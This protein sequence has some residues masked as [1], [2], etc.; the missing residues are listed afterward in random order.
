MYL[1]Y[2]TADICAKE[3]KIHAESYEESNGA[4]LLNDSLDVET[5]KHRSFM[6]VFPTIK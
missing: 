2:I 1:I 6:A 4:V 5:A 3:A